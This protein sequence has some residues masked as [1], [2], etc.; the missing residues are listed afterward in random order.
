MTIITDRVLL[1]EDLRGAELA[2]RILEEIEAR[3]D[4]HKQSSW[5][6]SCGT[7][8]CIAGWA[9]IITGK[10]VFTDQGMGVLEL[11]TTDQRNFD[12]VAGELLELS[13]ADADKLFFLYDESIAKTALRQIAEGRGTIDWSF[14]YEMSKGKSGSYNDGDEND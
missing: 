13:P 1:D 10:A 5:G 11:V 8:A 3:P 6:T 4:S 9:A 2:Q 7:K 14:I 12:I